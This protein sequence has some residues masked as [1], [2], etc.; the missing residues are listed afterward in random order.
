MKPFHQ[1][2]NPFDLVKASD[3]SDSQI[4]EYWVDLTED[5]RGLLSLI[6][7]RLIM[8]MLLLG[9]KG[10][11]KTHLMRYCSA[12]VQAMR[13]GNLWSAVTTEGY[14]G[15]YVRADGLNH[16]QFSGK[17]QEDDV[18]ATIFGYYFELWVVINLLD[19]VKILFES[20]NS[21]EFPINQFLDQVIDLFN[22]DPGF[23]EKSL[24]G[25]IDYLKTA[26][27]KI[28]FSVNNSSLTRK[29]DNIIIT[30]SPGKLLFGIPSILANL[31][32]S[33]RDVIFL[34]M[35]DEVENLTED[36]QKFINTLIRYRKG[37]ATIKIGARLYGI[38]TYETNGSG[39]PI[40]Q[41]AEYELVELDAFLREQE[42]DYTELIKDLVRKRLERAGI[43]LNTNRED[44]LEKAFEPI[45][46]SNY[47]SQLLQF[48]TIGTSKSGERP[49]F[50]RLRKQLALFYKNETEPAID[51]ILNL[52]KLPEYPLLEKN[53]ILLFY[54]WANS[55]AEFI[56]V[57]RRIA[58]Q[59]KLFA[60]G[61]RA[62]AEDYD[63]TL[64]HFDSDLLAQLHRD[65]RRKI[66]YAG[67]ENFVRS[68]QGVP[69]NLLGILK[70]VYR[71]SLFAG[72]SPFQGGVIS[73]QAQ[74]DG[75]MDS[76]AWFWDDSQPD[77]YG[78][79]VRESIERLAEF[80]RSVR[81]SD[82]PAECDLCTFNVNVD[83]LTEVSQKTLKHAENWSYL[84]RIR[85]GSKNK[86][87]K[88]IDEKFQL[89][90][91]LA[92]KWGLSPHRRGTIE[93]QPDLANSIFGKQ[94]RSEFER[95]L[96]LRISR[97]LAP[98]LFGAN[99][100]PSHPGLFS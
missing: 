24:T 62:S 11:G 60:S 84:I 83:G 74:T 2:D 29:L 56:D 26:Q 82:K 79:E 53:N 14:L 99:E 7:P 6:K 18:W 88:R 4:Y 30:F 71:R 25:L 44:D 81:Y 73:I 8:P 36:Q 9:G 76:A 32:T 65:Y 55:S 98:N 1:D 85:D 94:D 75:V 72:E 50:N 22:I 15:T 80:F 40:R 35:I 89:S 23:K 100:G 31:S 33:L 67:L 39:E 52:L 77:K 16:G 66:P 95:L 59:A 38:L 58:E 78:S 87:T 41:N 37:N 47:Y 54:K 57:A 27:K 20:P 48:V 17:G 34:Y 3:F 96:K 91:M 86:N 51:E 90:P 43:T 5:S 70:N 64:K 19:N 68:S 61:N 69:R 93:I 63:Q 97:M 12:P 45:N 10:S 42:D 92:P 49:Y 28:D 21:D 46:S 13:T